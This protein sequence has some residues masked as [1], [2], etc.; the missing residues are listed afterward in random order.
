MTAVLVTGSSGFLGHAIASALTKRSIPTIGLDPAPARTAEYKTIIDDLSQPS[1]IARHLD[2]HKITH[3]IH[4]GG[5]SAPQL[6]EATDMLGI[7]AGGSLNLLLSCIPAGI[8]RVVY[9]SSTAVLGMLPKQTVTAETPIRPRNAY[10]FSK[11][12]VEQMIGCIRTQGLTQFCILRFGGIYGPGRSTPILP[13]RLIEAA[14]SGEHVSIPSG[15]ATSYIF[16]DDAADAAISACFCETTEDEPYHI[17]HPELVTPHQLALAVREFIPSFSFEMTTKTQKQFS[18]DF[19]ITSAQ[20]DFG[21]DPKINIR[22]GIG[23]VYRSK[24]QTV[25][26]PEHR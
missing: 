15:N 10:A 20:R 18:P 17:V 16:I 11:S 5:I 7:N 13:N 8:K 26:Q 24:L 14:I 2:H 19:D 4:C 21:F 12:A 25:T 6:A 1:R 3:I 23:L 9:A 22:S